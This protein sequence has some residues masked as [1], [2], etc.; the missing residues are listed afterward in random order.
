M[1]PVANLNPRGIEQMPLSNIQWLPVS[2]LDANDYNPN[3]VITPEFNLL[4]YNLLRHGWIQPLLIA[5]DGERFVIIDGFH[6]ATLTKTDPQVAVMT[7]GM[8]PCV[9][10]DLPRE[11]RMLLTVRINRA[12]G[13]HVALKMHELL[14]ELVH[15]LGI[16]IERVAEGIGATVH[17]VQTLLTENLFKKM[18]VKNISYTQA[19]KPK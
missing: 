7:N 1:Q 13:T 3:V 4:R 18:N 6:R 17:E 14:H 15:D 9:V 2:A 8:V 12:K 16:P 19:W 11:E 5:K 10:M